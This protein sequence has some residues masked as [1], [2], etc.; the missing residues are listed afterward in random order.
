MRTGAPR[1]TCRSGRSTCSTT[2]CCASRCGPSTSSPRLLGHWGTT[3][4]LNLVYAHLNRAIRQRD[5]DCLYI[6]GPGHGGPGLVA[7]TWLE[8][9][10]TSDGT[11]RLQRRA[12]DGMRYPL[13]AYARL[14]A[15]SRVPGGHSIDH[16]KLYC[17]PVGELCCSLPHETAGSNP[18][19]GTASS[20]SR[21]DARPYGRRRHLPSTFIHVVALLRV[22]AR[23][24][25]CTFIC[26]EAETG[27]LAGFFEPALRQPPHV[28]C[29]PHPR[30]VT[31][32]VSYFAFWHVWCRVSAVLP[33]RH[34][35]SIPRV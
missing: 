34:G 9:S 7:N 32:Y 27:R 14:S 3:P 20:A 5:L 24:F 30:S 19:C 6:T 13:L 4:G 33:V 2:R 35:Q 31:P 17:V 25:V 8:G 11:T 21:A 28:M 23:I 10:Y 29:V 15:S 26:G 16:A 18:R 1:T 22:S 12:A